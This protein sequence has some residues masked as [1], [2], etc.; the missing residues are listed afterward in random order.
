MTWSVKQSTGERE[1]CTP[2]S[3]RATTQHIPAT[4]RAL[5]VH[6]HSLTP[7][8]TSGSP[9]PGGHYS[10]SFD[11]GQLRYRAL[12][13]RRRQGGAGAG[14]GAGNRLRMADNWVTIRSNSFC[15]GLFELGHAGAIALVS[16]GAHRVRREG[17]RSGAAGSAGS[18]I[19][20]H[21][22][23]V[24][25]ARAPHNLKIQRAV[26]SPRRSS[27]IGRFCFFGAGFS[28]AFGM[29]TTYDFLAWPVCKVL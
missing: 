17:R 10:V 12:V 14:C 22:D 26:S 21:G 7:A 19:L 20:L 9:L 28:R 24:Q 23:N 3:P 13:W 5:P 29:I 27:D 18:F 16:C 1:M 2:S 6:W 15:R 4:F 25:P 8:A 11:F